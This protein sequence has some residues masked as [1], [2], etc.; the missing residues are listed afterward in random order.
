M[1]W[2]IQLNGIIKMLVSKTP[3]RVSFLGG[4]TDLP[5]WYSKNNA[6]VISTSID[7]Y[8]Y[9][10][11]R[12][13][14]SIFNYKFRLRY[15]KTEQVK[16]LEQIEHN[17]FREALKLL[18]KKKHTL[19]IVHNSD[20]PSLSGLAGSSTTTA[21]IVNLLLKLEKKNSKKEILKKTLLIEQNILNERVGSQDQAA[22]VYGGF[23]HINFKKSNIKIKKLNNYKA[24]KKIE[25]SILLIFTKN[26]QSKKRN[27]INLKSKMLKKNNFNAFQDINQITLE[28]LNLINGNF[29]IKYFG[30]LINEYW[31]IKKSLNKSTTNSKIDY[32]DE[33]CSRLGCYGGKLLG[34][35]GGGFFMVLADK[36]AKKKIKQK[37]K[38]NVLDIKF[39]N[40]GTKIINF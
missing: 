12:F 4:G 11:L 28:G 35:G 3:F 8:S 40:C 39:E 32:I 17:T 16:N 18:Y 37:F 24:I 14:P 20:I 30:S 22:C 34:A 21:G 33:A 1:D 25:D 6:N 10:I 36:Y 23:N 13:L 27:K 19:E 31:K 26:R 9:V 5:E 7:K 38:E 29:D 2:Y 15:F